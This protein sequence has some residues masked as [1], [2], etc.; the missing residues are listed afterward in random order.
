[1][2]LYE[3]KLVIEKRPWEPPA[4]RQTGLRTLPDSAF[5]SNALGRDASAASRRRERTLRR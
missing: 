4:H 1:M 5:P 2:H 3:S